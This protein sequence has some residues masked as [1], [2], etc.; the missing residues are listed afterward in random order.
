MYNNKP[1]TKKMPYTE[2]PIDVVPTSRLRRPRR[3]LVFDVMIFL[4]KTLGAEIEWRPKLNCK[5]LQGGSPCRVD[6]AID[7]IDIH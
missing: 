1:P 7:I 3:N 4:T 2:I 5:I 6:A